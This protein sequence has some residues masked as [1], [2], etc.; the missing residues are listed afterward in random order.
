MALNMTCKD[1]GYPK[2]F[3]FVVT[4]LIVDFVGFLLLPSKIH[5]DAIN[6]MQYCE[7]KM[8]TK[9]EMFVKCGHKDNF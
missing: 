3:L 7:A 2:S 8:A 6:D 4:N 1:L 5:A 9:S